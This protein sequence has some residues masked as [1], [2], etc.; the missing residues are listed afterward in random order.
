MAARDHIEQALRAL[1]AER[2][3]RLTERARLDAEIERMDRLIESLATSLE[4]LSAEAPPPVPPPPAPELEPER[5]PEVRT[6]PYTGMDLIDAAAAVL[7][8]RGDMDSAE[9][10]RHLLAGG[11]RTRAQP[12]TFSETIRTMLRRH[13]ARERGIGRSDDGL[14]TIR[15]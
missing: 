13:S 9:L 3:V 5:V 6:G 12:Q 11:F 8:Q 15:T 2:E 10:A 14:W 1:E 4:E 7:S